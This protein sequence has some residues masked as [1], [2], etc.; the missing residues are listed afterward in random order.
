MSIGWTAVIP[1][2]EDLRSVDRPIFFPHQHDLAVHGHPDSDLIQNGSRLPRIMLS[3]Y[4]LT[5]IL[6]IHFRK[7]WMLQKLG[8]RRTLL[9]LVL[10]DMSDQV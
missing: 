9:R 5:T 8:G 2:L 6:D 3:L 7:P 10:Q 1:E 4:T